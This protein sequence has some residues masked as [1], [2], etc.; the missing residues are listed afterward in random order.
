MNKR[1]TDRVP[2]EMQEQI[3]L[4]EWARLMEGQYPE[5]KLMFHVPN[6]GKRS[7]IMGRQLKRMGLKPGV[8]DV[9]LPVAKGRYHGLAIE[10]KNLRGR[11]SGDQLAWIECL[12]GVGWRA[13]ICHGWKEAVDVIRAYL[14]GL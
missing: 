2:T 7:Q 12:R 9:I 10:M 6:E 11:P 8:P 14:S 13:E 3:W 1:M 5:L 4:F